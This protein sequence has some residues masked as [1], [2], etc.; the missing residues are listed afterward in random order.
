VGVADRVAVRV[1][2]WISTRPSADNRAR[3]V[4]PVQHRRYD[5]LIGAITTLARSFARDGVPAAHAARVIADAI[6]TSRP[7]TRTP[8][9]APPRSS[10]AS[11]GWPPIGSATGVLR[12]T[13]KPHYSAN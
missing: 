1:Q 11:P 12:R 5:A 4:T 7:R 3:A 10:C 2:P 6:T 8:S 13:L 9:D